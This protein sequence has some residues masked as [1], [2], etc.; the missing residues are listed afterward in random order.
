MVRA[1]YQTSKC[2]D[3]KKWVSS[4]DRGLYSHW[5]ATNGGDQTKLC[6]AKR[7]E[8]SELCLEGSLDFTTKMSGQRQQGRGNLVSVL[9]CADCA[10]SEVTSFAGKNRYSAPTWSGNTPGWPQYEVKS[11]G[12]MMLQNGVVKMCH[13]DGSI[14]MVLFS[15]SWHWLHSPCPGAARSN[16]SLLG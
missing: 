3:S 7:G 10:P 13:E 6:L 8:R 12:I 14:V 9:P 15:S 11:W 5:Q 2:V 16:C 1:Y 4:C